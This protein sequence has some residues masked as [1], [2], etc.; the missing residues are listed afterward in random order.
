MNFQDMLEVLVDYKRPS[1]TK[2]I[3]VMSLEGHLCFQRMLFYVLA[4]FCKT[5][6]LT[7]CKTRKKTSIR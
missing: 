7:T 3:E 6:T 2:L 4:V 5:F 1:L